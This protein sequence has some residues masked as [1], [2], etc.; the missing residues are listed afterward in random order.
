[1]EERDAWGT[2][3]GAFCMG[4]T[5]G[6]GVLGA[7]GLGAVWASPSSGAL[8]PSGGGGLGH[9]QRANTKAPTPMAQAHFTVYFSEEAASLMEREI[10]LASLS[11]EITMA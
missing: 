8:G 5:L 10:F 9:H 1:M 3:E 11:R 4:M 7:W 2:G 6:L